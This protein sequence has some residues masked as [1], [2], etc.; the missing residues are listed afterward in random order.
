MN[1]Q[2][3]LYGRIFGGLCFSLALLPVQLESADGIFDELLVCLPGSWLVIQAKP[4]PCAEDGLVLGDGISRSQILVLRGSSTSA[5][6][7]RA[8]RCDKGKV[9]GILSDRMVL[10][11][12]LA[13]T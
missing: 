13:T 5:W 3:P 10:L 2:G 12:I 8:Y 9:I 4:I 7:D 11:S 6:A 1:I